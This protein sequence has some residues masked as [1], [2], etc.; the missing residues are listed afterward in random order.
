MPRNAIAEDDV[1]AVL[2]LDQLAECLVA[3]AAGSPF[4]PSQGRRVP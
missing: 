1:D 3:L 4:E 2:V